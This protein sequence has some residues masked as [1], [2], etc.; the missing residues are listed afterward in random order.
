MGKTEW[1]FFLARQ[2]IAKGNKVAFYSLE[3]SKQAMLER[4]ARRQAGVTRYDKQIQN[5]NL[6]QKQYADQYLAELQNTD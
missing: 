6:T 2:N 3:L 5:Y 4:T 1:C